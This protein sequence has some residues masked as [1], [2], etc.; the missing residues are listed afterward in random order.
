MKETAITLRSKVNKTKGEQ[1][2]SKSKAQDLLE[3]ASTV[4]TG[5]DPAFRK[6][7]S[8]PEGK[9]PTADVDDTIDTPP[10][11]DGG[12]VTP[13]DM[14]AFSDKGLGKMNDQKK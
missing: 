11:V 6:G 3:M 7:T 14:S 12:K 10:V 4:I 1:E 13:D 9:A 5:K 8:E 2:M